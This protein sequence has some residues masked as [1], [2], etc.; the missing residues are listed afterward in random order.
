MLRRRFCLAAA[1]VA[2]PTA[3]QAQAPCPAAGSALVAVDHVPVAVR[4]LDA[5]VAD[6]RALGFSFKPGRPHPNSILNQHIKFRD[7][8]EVELITATEPRDT[9]ARDY[10]EFL[11]G[12]EGGAFAALEGAPDSVFAALHGFTPGVRTGGGGY[13]RWTDFRYGD[14][15]RY[16][17][18]IRLDA[19]PVDLPEQ[20][21]HTNTAVRLHAIWL[22]RADTAP[23]RRLL[24]RLG[25]LACPSAVALPI[26]R[27][28]EVRLRSGSMYLVED[29][30]AQARRAVA[31]VTLEVA[32]VAAARRAMQLPD[33]GV[34]QGS[35]A[36]GRWLRVPPERAHGIWLELLQPDR[37]TS[38][39][40][41]GGL[42]AFELGDPAGRGGAAA[43]IHLGRARGQ[44]MH[45]PPAVFVRQSGNQAGEQRLGGGQ[46]GLTLNRRLARVPGEELLAGGGARN[47]AVD[48]LQQPRGRQADL[49]AQSVERRALSLPRA[50]HGGAQN[51]ITRHGFARGAHSGH[52]GRKQCPA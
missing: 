17:F 11:R 49:V 29:G 39:R 46:L 28:A 47:G 23:E 43:A 15:L 4:D 42:R 25:G 52:S 38:V 50:A 30:A 24:A 27:A 31:G 3:V 13:A 6:F 10:V 20:V 16:L 34:R 5:A 8:S 51:V 40:G 7:G 9:L 21:T 41:R 36:R 35:D 22:R 33:G 44:R 32:D 45:Q 19:R 48:E 1:L 14:P 2:L 12:G 18:V 37:G 26:G